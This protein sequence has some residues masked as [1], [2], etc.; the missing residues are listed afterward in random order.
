MAKLALLSGCISFFLAVALGAF[1]AHAL[2][3]LLVANQRLDVFETASRYHF[4]H[5]I[6]LLILGVLAN[7]Q[8]Q[9]KSLLLI[10]YL[11]IAGTLGFSGSLYLLAITDIAA[12]GVITPIGGLLLLLAWLLLARDVLLNSD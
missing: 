7:R 2:E 12:L 3:S 11:F 10:C 1:G 9:F 6:A 8:Y 4:Y 5:S